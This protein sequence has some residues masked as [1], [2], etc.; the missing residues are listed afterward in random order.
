[1]FVG[2]LVLY[3]LLGLFL[4]W[5]LQRYIDPSAIKDPSKEATAKKDLLQAL[6]LI[7]AGVAGAI[8]IFFTW[9]SQRLAREAQEEN[10]QNTQEQLRNAQE[11]LQLTRQGQITE[12]FTT[13]IDHL[14]HDRTEIRLGGV[15]ALERIAKESEED[16]WPIMEILTY[17]VRGLAPMPASQ[18]HPVAQA[19]MTVIGRRSRYYRNRELEPLDLSGAESLRGI[20]LQRANLSG[21]NLSGANLRRTNIAYAQLEMANGDIN[22]VLPD[23]V[24]TPPT[25]WDVKPDGLETPD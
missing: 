22:T 24:K 17:Y 20:V 12:R 10:Q 7:M 11:E 21:A 23:H 8:G 14:G 3:L 16:H 13:A 5:L 1:L 19:I 4:W 6:G 25:S 15:Y 9:R 2:G 18:V